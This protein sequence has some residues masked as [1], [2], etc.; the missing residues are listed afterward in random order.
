MTSKDFKTR[1][2]ETGL[3][4]DSVDR[5]VSRFSRLFPGNENIDS[6]Y[7]Y[8]LGNMDTNNLTEITH[9]VDVADVVYF[10]GQSILSD[11]KHAK[12][13]GFG[14]DKHEQLDGVILAGLFHDVA[15]GYD[16]TE[17]QRITGKELVHRWDKNNGIPEDGD[18][19]RGGLIIEKEVGDKTGL[20]DRSVGVAIDILKNHG[21][22]EYPWQTLVEFGD[23]LA[24]I[25]GDN[26]SRAVIESYLLKDHVDSYR[27]GKIDEKVLEREI[28]FWKDVGIIEYGSQLGTKIKWDHE[29]AQ[30][31]MLKKGFLLL[32]YMGKEMQEVYAKIARQAETKNRIGFVAPDVWAIR[33][34]QAA[35]SVLKDNTGLPSNL[36]RKLSKAYEE[37]FKLREFYSGE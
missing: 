7:T 1:V 24:Y 18:S 32:D 15:L 28:D 6:T 9:C 25:N 13:F 29:A 10:L 16:R 17:L 37:A 20:S 31:R 30:E 3:G 2:S 23:A 21:Q 33:N 8:V 14:P 35:L 22:L 27:K 5:L 34:Y 4:E 11:S 36:A 26:H 19:Y 12:E